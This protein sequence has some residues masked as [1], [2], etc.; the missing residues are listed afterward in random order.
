[1]G[2]IPA[3]A[4]E[5]RNR[6]DIIYPRG[7]Y[8]RARGGTLV[9]L[10][11][12]LCGEGLSPRTRGNLRLDVAG[13]AVPGSIP[14]HAGE[15]FSLMPHISSERVY[16]R[17]RGGTA[18]ALLIISPSMGLSPRTRGNQPASEPRSF[19]P[20]SIPAHAGEPNNKKSAMAAARVYPRARGG[21]E[22]SG[23]AGE[24]F[25][26]L[27]PRTRGNHQGAGNQGP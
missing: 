2:S 20:G 12:F 3:H 14:A 9:I 17:A 11:P 7:V 26:G 27:S 24:D 10:C 5:P 4:G 22:A 6:R 1:M 23:A 13:V 21:T 19:R 16:P 25:Q 8:P 18:P 15:P